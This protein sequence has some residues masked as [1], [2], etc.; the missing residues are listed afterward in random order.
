MQSRSWKRARQEQSRSKAGSLHLF[1]PASSLVQTFIG[2]I[3]RVGAGQEQE[4]CRSREEEGQKQEKNRGG[5][6]QSRAGARKEQDPG[7]SR[8]CA[9]AG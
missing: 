8:K 3:S 9:G 7:R 6:V 1:W 5:A 2:R 4:R